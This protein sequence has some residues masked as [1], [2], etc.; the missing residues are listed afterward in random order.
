MVRWRVVMYTCAEEG[1][2]R[3]AGWKDKTYQ[4]KVTPKMV[5][6]LSLAPTRQAVESPLQA[7]RHWT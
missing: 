7:P 3:S 1:R 5:T 6:L 2:G 4:R